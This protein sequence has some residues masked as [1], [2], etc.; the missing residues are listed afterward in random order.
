M[1]TIHH[2]AGYGRSCPL[3]AL[4]L[5]KDQNIGSRIKILLKE[6][7]VI[8][9]GD[10]VDTTNGRVILSDE[11]EAE[12]ECEELTASLVLEV[13][14]RKA[15]GST[16]V[17]VNG[18]VT[19]TL[20]R[21]NSTRSRKASNT[22]ADNPFGAQRSISS[23]SIPEYHPGT[24]KRSPA[25]SRGHHS[26]DHPDPDDPGT[27]TQI[28]NG[29]PASI[30]AQKLTTTE[31]LA[32]LAQRTE[33]FEKQLIRARSTLDEV[34]DGP[35][36]EKLSEMDEKSEEN[37][38][39][40]K[41]LYEEAKKFRGTLRKDLPEYRVRESKENFEM[42]SMSSNSKSQPDLSTEVS[43]SGSEVDWWLRAF[44]FSPMAT[45]M[46]RPIFCHRRS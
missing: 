4:H 32:L 15:D 43:I 34:E 31:F 8:V 26:A 11:S 21:N 16:D 3:T 35:S 20:S 42:V 18:F 36:P 10:Y 2:G 19:P 23:T 12:D 5:T 9:N 13:I 28:P 41:N 1:T 24:L 29:T 25:I 45:P 46:K 27:I 17:K 39:H 14:N 40:T 30:K 38:E 22:H 7:P 6:M 44:N 33:S 37:L